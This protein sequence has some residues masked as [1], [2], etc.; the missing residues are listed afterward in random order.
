MEKFLP[1]VAY[2]SYYGLFFCPTKKDFSRIDSI[3]YCPTLTVTV[4]TVIFFKGKN[5]FLFFGMT[6]GQT[7]FF[8]LTT[9][10]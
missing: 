3:F 10:L 4:S 5:W 7:F 1:D 9:D 8:P 6:F 2:V